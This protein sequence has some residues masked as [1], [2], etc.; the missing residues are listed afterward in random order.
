MRLEAAQIGLDIQ[1][2]AEINFIFYLYTPLPPPCPRLS[3]GSVLPPPPALPSPLGD[4]LSWERADEPLLPPPELRGAPS[5]RGKPT[6]SPSPLLL[7]HLQYQ[8]TFNLH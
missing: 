8:L 4:A 7:S 1:Q 6:A 3:P 2:E 5:H